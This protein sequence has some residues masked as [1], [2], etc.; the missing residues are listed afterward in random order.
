M[1]E[2]EVQPE[3]AER[4]RYAFY[5]QPDESV[6]IARSANICQTCIDCGCGDQQPPIGPYPSHIVQAVVL[7]GQGKMAEAMKLLMSKGI[8]VPGMAAMRDKGP[9]RSGRR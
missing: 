6:I 1:S 8:R 2:P 7:I 3:P 4:G 5:V 9:V